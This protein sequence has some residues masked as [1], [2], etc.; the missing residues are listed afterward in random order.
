MTIS[1]CMATYNGSKYILDQINSILC[2][3]QVTELLIS[4]DGSTD[5]T[6]TLIYSINDPRVKIFKNQ[7]LG[8]VRNFEFLIRQAKCEFI[9][10][11][12]QDDVWLSGKVESCVN[13]LKDFDLVISDCYVVD[14]ELNITH[15]SFFE[16]NISSKGLLNNFVKNSYLGCCMAFRST[17]VK[18]IL[19]IPYNVPM[20]D[21]W[22]GLIAES[23]GKIYFD[24]RKYIFYR[25]HSHNASTSSG[26][27]KSSLIY[28]IRWRLLLAYHLS[29]RYVSFLLSIFY[30]KSQS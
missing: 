21:W 15:D 10:L 13:R 12:D 26:K 22:I 8:I 3:S 16:L 5:E 14:C 29:I 7:H 28:K 17:L 6:L 2:N 19:P 4:D 25:R 11:S 9:F 27:S 1:V 23:F 24:N 20:H 30:N 18:Y